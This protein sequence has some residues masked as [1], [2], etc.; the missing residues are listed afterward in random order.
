MHKLGIK[1]SFKLL[2]SGKVK[3]IGDQSQNIFSSN[4]NNLKFFCGWY[5]RIRSAS[6]LTANVSWETRVGKL[7][8]SW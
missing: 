3:A 2:L 1:E 6:L 8:N 7:S 5:N 4:E